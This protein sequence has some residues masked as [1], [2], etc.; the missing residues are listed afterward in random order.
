MK[1][2]HMTYKSSSY[3][4]CSILILL[5]RDH[6]FN[7]FILLVQMLFLVG[8]NRIDNHDTIICLFLKIHFYI[9]TSPA[10]PNS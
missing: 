3:P 1:E 5:P 9:I 8:P 10:S 4:T 6:L 2:T 7:W